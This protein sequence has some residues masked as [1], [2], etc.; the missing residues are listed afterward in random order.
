LRELPGGGGNQ[1]HSARTTNGG[2][3][4]YVEGFNEFRSRKESRE[5]NFPR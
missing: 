3:E 2:K 1:K 5:L 4:G